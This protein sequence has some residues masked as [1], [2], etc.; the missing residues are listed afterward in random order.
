MKSRLLLWLKAIGLVLAG[1]VVIYAVLLR[2]WHLR[3][4]T[5]PAE[6]HGIL[7]GDEL[8]P[9]AAEQVT[10]AI[11]IDAPPEKV[12]PWLM[13]IGQDRSGFYSYTFLEN[14]IGCEMPEIHQL[15]SDWP[16]RHPGETVWFGSPKHFHG[17][18]RM[19]AGRIDPQKAFVMVMPA[20]W[21]KI[22]SGGQAR[23]SSWGFVVQPI[24]G[25]RSR[26]IARLRSGPPANPWNQ[27]IG[28]LFWEPAH[29]VME[30]RMLLTIKKLAE[31]ES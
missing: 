8:V 24:D 17:D 23:E 11:T 7:P 29:F 27:F 2:P 4:G 1:F 15:R 16:S 3:W 10:H 28:A 22:Q 6:A 12:W 30:R 18:A 21:Q 13:Q 14:L 26:L 19:V 31:T 5:T 9:S 20:D 25:G